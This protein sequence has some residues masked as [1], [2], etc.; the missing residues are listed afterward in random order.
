M[1]YLLILMAL[2]LPLPLLQEQPPPKIT[3]PEWILLSVG[4]LMIFWV[5][6]A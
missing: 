2:L 4:Y 5:L 3:L 6:L 1:I